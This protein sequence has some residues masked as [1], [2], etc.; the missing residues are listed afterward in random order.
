M[1]IRSTH[2]NPLDE[3]GEIIEHIDGSIAQPLDRLLLRGCGARREIPHEIWRRTIQSKAPRPWLELGAVV[4]GWTLSTYIAPNVRTVHSQ[5]HVGA[6]SR[7]LSP[8]GAGG[9]SKSSTAL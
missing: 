8:D 3:R 4:Q 5:L 6:D 9:D 2:G 1:E 7:A